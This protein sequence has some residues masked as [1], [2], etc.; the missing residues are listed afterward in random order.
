MTLKSFICTLTIALTSAG[1]VTATPPAETVSSPRVPTHMEFAGQKYDLTRTDLHERLD[2]ELTN[3]A[4]GH[5]S[6]FQILK[7]APRYLPMMRRILADNGVPADMVYLACIESS[8]NPTA[9]SPAKAAGLWQ[10]M[11]A[12]AKE[13]GLEVN[14]YVDER[15]HPE[16]ATRA[17][18]R[19]L[20]KAKARFGD[21]LTA[22]ASYNAGQ[23][24]IAGQLDAQLQESALDLWLVD[25]TSRYPFRLLAAKILLENPK[26]LGFDVPASQT[27]QPYET[28]DV[29]VSGPVDDWAEWASDRGFSYLTLRLLNPWIRKPQLPNKTARKYIV[30]IPRKGTSMRP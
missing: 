4:F 22:A 20:K 27:Y 1:T 9:L 5:S 19:Y 8:L 25:E 26:S 21:W 7:R 3:F 10:L 16:K 13:Y 11:P 24:R 17:A 28:E 23:A 15:Y 18:A 12:T 29:T 2:R 30:K 6:S 14:E